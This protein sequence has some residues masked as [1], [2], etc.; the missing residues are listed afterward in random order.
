MATWIV[1]T[2]PGD[3]KKNNY[4]AIYNIFIMPIIKKYN[5]SQHKCVCD[6]FTESEHKIK[7]LSDAKK[8]SKELN[9]LFKKIMKEM[10]F[11]FEDSKIKPQA[12]VMPKSY[13]INGDRT[14]VRPDYSF[15]KDYKPKYSCKG[16]DKELSI[17]YKERDSP[18]FSANKYPG[19]IM[20][21]NDNKDYKSTANKNKIYA[22][23][24]L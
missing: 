15:D 11:I 13:E 18:P 12:N 8:C 17:K 9:S 19:K 20:K 10:S 24:L 4:Q 16:F 6:G 3:Y 2:L 22:W 14:I 1:I 21:G 5:G 23:K 7:T